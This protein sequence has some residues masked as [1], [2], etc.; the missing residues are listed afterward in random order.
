MRVNAKKTWLLVPCLGVPT[1]FPNHQTFFVKLIWPIS[2][3]AFLNLVSRVRKLPSANVSDLLFAFCFFLLFEFDSNKW[4][5]GGLSPW[6]WEMTCKRSTRRQVHGQQQ[7]KQKLILD[8]YTNKNARITHN[9]LIRWSLGLNLT[10]CDVHRLIRCV[11]LDSKLRK[12]LN[13]RSCISFKKE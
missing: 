12:M 2:F 7:Q 8:Y 4:G 11:T 1:V 9:Y 10:L 6:Q 5:R 13:L 3:F